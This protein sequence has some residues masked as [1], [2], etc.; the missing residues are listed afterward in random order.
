[1]NNN[2]YCNKNLKNLKYAIP[3]KNSIS[4]L[5]FLSNYIFMWVYHDTTI[6]VTLLPSMV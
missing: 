5:I 4:I 2:N 6:I 3:H 1:M